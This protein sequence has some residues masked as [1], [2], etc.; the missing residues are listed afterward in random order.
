MP[1]SHLIHMGVHVTTCQ[2]RCNNFLSILKNKKNLMASIKVQNT[3]IKMCGSYTYCS[4][5]YVE[6]KN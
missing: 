5:K 1:H 3:I 4:V 6:M 2:T